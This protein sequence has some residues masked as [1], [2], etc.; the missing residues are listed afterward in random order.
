MR[1][2][3]DETQADK[4][5][6]VINRCPYVFKYDP[7]KY[8]KLCTIMDRYQDTVKYLN[9]FD[10]PYKDDQFNATDFIMWVNYAD[11]II[12]CIKELNNEFVVPN[13]TTFFRKDGIKLNGKVKGK[14]KN[15]FP[16]GQSDDD[17]YFK[18]IRAIVLAH[19]I[20]INA[21]R[22]FTNGLAFSPLVRWENTHDTVIITYYY[23]ADSKWD[24]QD[25]IIN[26]KNMIEY[27]ESRCNY[28][29]YIFGYIEKENQNAKNIIIEKYKDDFMNLP[30]GRMD[31][32]EKI[33]EVHKKNGDIDTKNGASIVLS[34]LKQVDDCISY[35]F[36]PINILQ[37]SVFEK[38]VD[39]MLDDLVEYLRQQKDDFLLNETLLA[40]NY[41]NEA[42]LFRG[43]IY[44]IN[45]IVSEYCDKE[46]TN[47]LLFEELIGKIKDNISHYVIIND[48]MSNLEKSF[49]CMIAMIFDSIL[50]DEKIRKKF[51][52][53]ITKEVGQI[54]EIQI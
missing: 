36:N 27:L 9:G 31:K 47:W 34:R 41:N 19:A 32:I 13:D 52:P 33:R 15:F 24:T 20:K 48:E 29:D 21:H 40:C 16:C 30:K 8:C 43:N 4:L 10:L 7:E 50:T 1:C 53:N 37:I 35:Q 14:T 54:Y 18:F 51:P 2:C 26:I 6:G 5:R 22:Q 17:D 46:Q 25:I 42:S 49:L 44:E 39:Y 45:K 28:L 23:V 38:I 3:L 12:N 11:L